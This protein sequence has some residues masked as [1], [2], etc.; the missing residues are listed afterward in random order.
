MSM[1]AILPVKLS[2]TEGDYYTLWAPEWREHGA[3]WQG[4]L[5][6]GEKLYF[7]ES[8]AAMLA[9]LESGTQHDLL[10]HPRWQAFAALPENRVEPSEREYFDIIGMPATLAE[11]P[12][13]DHVST[14]AATMRVARALAE[15][16]GAQEA[17]GFFGSHSI[18]SNLERGIEHY[19]GEHGEQEW[20]GVGRVVLHNWQQVVHS[21]DGIF[22]VVQP[23]ESAVSGAK[24]RLDAAVSA[25]AES[26][27][28]EEE[29]EKEAKEAADPYDSTVWAAAGIDPIKISIDGSTLYTLRTYLRGVPVFLGRYGEIFTFNNRKAL[30]RWLIANDTHDLATVSTWEDVLS[31]ANAGELEVTVHAD[32][33]YSF[34]GMERAIAKSVDA[35]DTA[36][37]A[38]CYELLADAAD[39]AGDDSLNSFFLAHPRMQDYIS[40]MLGSSETVGYV[41]SAPFTQHSNDWKEMEQ[42]LV[43]RFSRT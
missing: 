12:S 2:L 19:R 38:R 18:L 24:E 5:G 26:R 4:F 17:A 23:K 37:M 41:P 13:Y 15:V 25:A 40:Y 8:T 22:E 35:V 29:R 7:F 31:A 34:N 39:W 32:N 11:R 21:L 20:S 16:G 14:V 28:Q 10:D 3:K 30:V 27:R 1:R 43:K 9:F 6:A 33:V 36:Q 42:M